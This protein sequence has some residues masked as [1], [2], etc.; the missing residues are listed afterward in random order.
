ML[1]VGGYGLRLRTVIGAHGSSMAYRVC[2]PRAATRRPAGPEARTGG[3]R[4]ALPLPSARDVPKSR[5]RHGLG[6][7]ARETKV[8]ECQRRSLVC[9]I[10]MTTKATKT[11]K[12]KT[13]LNVPKTGPPGTDPSN[14]FIDKPKAVSMLPAP[15]TAR[16]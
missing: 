3:T 12:A 4:S 7:T 6:S 9:L 15:D 10:N 2:A 11:T 14:M 8:E 13:R 5:T 16:R 1:P